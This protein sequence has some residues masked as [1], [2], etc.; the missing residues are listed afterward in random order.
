MAG[1]DGRRDGVDADVLI[2]GAG[3]AGLMAAR[4]LADARLNVLVVERE[5]VAGGRLATWRSGSDRAD[6]GAQFFTVRTTE[7]GAA[8]GQW[9]VEE[10]IFEWTRGWS[11]GSLL[12]DRPDGYPRYAAR[13]GFAALARNLSVGLPIR[14]ATELSALAVDGGG[15]AAMTT[16]HE[17]LRSR[18]LILTPPVP[19]SLA[20]LDA[21]HITLPDEQRMVLDAI[22][23]GPCLSG[24]FVVDGD[25][26]LPEPGALQRP[27]APIS[28]V[29]DNKRKGISTASRTLTVHASPAASAERW[30]ESDEGVLAWMAAE[31]EPWLASGATVS[32]AALRRWPYAIPL[33]VYP[34]RYLTVPSPAPLIFAGDAFDGPRVEGAALSGWAAAD[35]LLERLNGRG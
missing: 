1:S 27:D 34:A 20:L 12:D 10:W 18:A 2:A 33:S 8:V 25:L 32:R 5:A 17:R 16:T 15:W 24:V 9:M 22:R 4:R 3:L 11:D 23:Y 30:A 35:A 28:W 26:A 14:F 6:T 21:G 31:L 7:F 29:A 19:L 13:D